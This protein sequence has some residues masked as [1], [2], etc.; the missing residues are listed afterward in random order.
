MDDFV[1]FFLNII[2]KSPPVRGICT[3]GLNLWKF[4]EYFVCK[5]T[6][7]FGISSV[8]CMDMDTPDISLGVHSNLTASSFD[9]L[10]SM[11]T[12]SLALVVCLC[13][14]RIHNYGRVEKLQYS[15]M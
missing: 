1:P 4:L 15:R 12:D 14:L 11:K 9:F 5:L 3:N 8:C 6:A 10:A 7:S 2:N 13:A